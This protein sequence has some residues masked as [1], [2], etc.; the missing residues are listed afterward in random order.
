MRSIAFLERQGRYR[1]VPSG[2]VNVAFYMCYSESGKREVKDASGNVV[3]VEDVQV[4]RRQ[5][6]VPDDFSHKGEIQSDY[7]IANLNRLG[8]KP[9]VPVGDFVKAD[10]QRQSDVSDYLEGVDYTELSSDSE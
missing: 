3:S 7:S 4:S 6:L 10:L 5:A 8:V 9:T 1:H 2:E